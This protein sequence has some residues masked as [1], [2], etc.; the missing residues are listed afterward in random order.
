MNRDQRVL[1]GFVGPGEI[2]GLSS[3]LGQSTRPFRCEAYSDCT[4]AVVKP[5][6]FV[7]TVLGV[8]LERLSLVLDVTVGRWWGMVVRYANFVG[9]GLR[10]RLAGALLELA[11]KFGVR[12]SRHAADAQADACGAGGAG[13]S[14]A[15]AHDRA[16][17]RLRARG[18]HHSRGAAAD[19]RARETV[20]AC[21][22][23]VSELNG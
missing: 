14:V 22:N 21:A 7:D 20:E 13:G 5:D 18:R 15:A 6:I 11:E 3:L 8:P 17:E 2:F 19:N 10:E 4:A 16:I 1:V 12:D 9:L 23:A